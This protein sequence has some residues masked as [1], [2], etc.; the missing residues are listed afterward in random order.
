MSEIFQVLTITMLMSVLH[1]LSLSDSDL[2]SI[3]FVALTCN[4]TAA[5]SFDENATWAA[6]AM[7]AVGSKSREGCPF[8]KLIMAVGSL[9]TFPQRTAHAPTKSHPA[10]SRIFQVIHMSR[11]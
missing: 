9:C 1:P 5:A 8:S 3:Q 6:L 7:R 4:M 2:V 10:I 11:R